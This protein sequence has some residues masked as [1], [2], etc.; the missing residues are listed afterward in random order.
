LLLP[1]LFGQSAWQINLI[2][3]SSFASL[4]GSGA[5]AANA[6]ALQLMILPHGLIALSLGTVLYPTLA[7]LYGLGDLAGVRTQTLAALRRV[8]FFVLPAALALGVLT[9]PILEAL[10]QRGAFDARSTALTADALAAYAPGLIGF[11]AAEI[12]VRAFYAV[13]DTRTPVLIG[14]A[15]VAV[16]LFLGVLA[17]TS[18]LGLRGL[19][20]AFSIA[21]TYEA[22]ALMFLLFIRLGGAYA[23]FWGALGRMALCGLASG[24]LLA[25]AL[26]ARTV[27]LPILMPYDWPADFLPLLLWLA[28]AALLAGGAYIGCALV[29]RLSE[30]QELVQRRRN[31]TENRR[32]RNRTEN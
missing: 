29:L 17:V 22:L 8:T 25:L 14:I 18:G 19:G 13:Q 9:I 24:A 27:W 7:R 1:R 11:A 3:M 5:V 4:L 12:A 26:T 16:N 21:N 32:R 30:A 23:A 20:W 28:A 6:Y 15:A 31:R 10:F 2:A